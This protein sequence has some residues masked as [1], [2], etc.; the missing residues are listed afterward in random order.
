M[1]TEDLQL[2]VDIGILHPRADEGTCFLVW[3]KVIRDPIVRKRSSALPRD[4]A[5]P[6]MIPMGATRAVIEAMSE[7]EKA[8]LCERILAA[9]KNRKP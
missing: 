4:P 7:A 1:E 6:A 2:M 5:Y 9:C 3:G 8:E